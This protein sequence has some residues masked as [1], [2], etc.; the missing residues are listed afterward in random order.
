MLVSQDNR[1]HVKDNLSREIDFC[2]HGELVV[3]ASKL[4]KVAS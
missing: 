2:I 3:G 4:M 1:N